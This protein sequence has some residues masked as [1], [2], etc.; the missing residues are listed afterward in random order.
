M[1]ELKTDPKFKQTRKVGVAGGFFN[2]LMGNNKSVPVVGEGATYLMYSDRHAYEVISVD[3][4]NQSC[5]IERYDPERTDNLGMSDSQGYKYEKLTGSRLTLVWRK[6][7][8][9][10]WCVHSKEVRIIPKVLKEMEKVSNKWNPFD[11]IKEVYGQ[12]VYDQVCEQKDPDSRWAANIV[13]GIT[14]EYD[15]YHPFSIIFGVKQE[16]YDYSF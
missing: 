13:E 10:C 12:E 16:Y 7:Q 4:E 8:G 3:E 1:A 5:V 9:G 15:R 2:Q 6:K 14:K 11:Q